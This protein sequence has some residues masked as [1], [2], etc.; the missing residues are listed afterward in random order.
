MHIR[1]PHCRKKGDHLRSDFFGD[2]VVCPKCELPFPWR[3]AQ[4][5]ETATV[6]QQNGKHLHSSLIGEEVEK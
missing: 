5:G 3:D 6:L 4:I 2:W 1:C